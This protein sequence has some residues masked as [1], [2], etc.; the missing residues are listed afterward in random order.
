[1]KIKCV[2]TYTIAFLVSLLATVNAHSNESFELMSE[3]KAG[4]SIPAEYYG[5]QFGC[6]AQNLS[7]SLEWRN[8]PE[9]TRSFAI[10]VHDE[11]APTDS[12]FWHYLLI[13]IPADVRK[14][15]LGDLS[16]G[17]VPAG[18]LETMTDA[19]KPGYFG[20]CPPVGRTHIYRFKVYALKVAKLNVPTG[21]TPGFVSFNLWANTLETN[22]F[23]VTAGPRTQI[24]R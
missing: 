21:S 6:S 8:A 10:T 9:G 22:S 18:A 2:F 20:P 19:G 3:L 1:M 11:S 5:N 12:G 15:E 24:E 4:Q 13:D 17:K 14:V 7:P 23:T 16:H